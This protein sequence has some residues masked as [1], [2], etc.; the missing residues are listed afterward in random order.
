VR[1]KGYPS[2]ARSA[3][4]PPWRVGS[5]SANRLNW[6]A[7]LLHGVPRVPLVTARTT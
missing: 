2:P 5:G 6:T 4:E 7:I 1:G 3:I